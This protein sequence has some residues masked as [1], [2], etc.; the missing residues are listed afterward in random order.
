M[1]KKSVSLG[2]PEKSAA[3]RFAES[4]AVSGGFAALLTAVFL[5]AGAALLT[6]A[7]MAHTLFT[8]LTTALAALATLLCAYAAS[9]TGRTSGALSGAVCGAVVFLVLLGAALL[10]GCGALTRQALVKLAALLC[11]GTLGSLSGARKKQ[12]S[13]IKI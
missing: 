10:G 13:K 9:A 11:A 4:A 2:K 8:P 1:K 7:D 5:C 3:R 12:K 6:R